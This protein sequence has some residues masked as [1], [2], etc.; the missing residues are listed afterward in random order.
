MVVYGS[1]IADGNRHAH[2]DLPTLLA[3]GGALGLKHGRHLRWP[4]RTPLMNLHLELCARAGVRIDR[5]GDSTGRLE[6]L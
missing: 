3:G 2:Y 5:L 1:N 4:E 6:G